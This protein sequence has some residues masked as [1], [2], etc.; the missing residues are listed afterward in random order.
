MLLTRTSTVIRPRLL[1]H[2]KEELRAAHVPIMAAQMHEREAFRA[3]FSFGGT[4]DTLPPS[5]VSNLPAAAANARAVAAEV[6]SLLRPGA[7]K[8]DKGRAA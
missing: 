5:Q 1:A 6:V 8:L 3:I 2:I 7:S 4:I